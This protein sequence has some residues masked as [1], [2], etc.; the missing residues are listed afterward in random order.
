LAV[1]VPYELQCAAK[2]GTLDALIATYKSSAEISPSA[3]SL[4]AAAR[5]FVDLEID[6]RLERS[7]ISLRPATGRA[8]I[9]CLP[10]S[11]A[12]RRFALL[13]GD[14]PGAMTLLKRLVLTVGDQYQDM[15]S[16][17][18]LLERQTIRRKP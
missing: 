10:V 17:A 7:W 18:A 6:P 12:W 14:T 13:D 8:S 1:V 16:A 4:R 15:D 5:Q 9:V 2:L 3:E 11:S